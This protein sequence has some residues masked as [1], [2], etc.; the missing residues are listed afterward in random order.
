MV[1]WSAPPGGMK[2]DA[3]KKSITKLSD[4]LLDVMVQDEYQHETLTVQTES[5]KQE[6]FDKA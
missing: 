3:D 4:K 1:G 2:G 6:A 5:E